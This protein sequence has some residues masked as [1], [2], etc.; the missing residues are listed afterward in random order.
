MLCCC[1]Q[2]CVCVCVYVLQ[3]TGSVA[4]GWYLWIY[5]AAALIMRNC[6]RLKMEARWGRGCFST[7]GEDEYETLACVIY[8]HTHTHTHTFC[9]HPPSLLLLFLVVEIHRS[10]LTNIKGTKES[11]NKA[12]VPDPFYKMKKRKSKAAEEISIPTLIPA[13]VNFQCRQPLRPVKSNV[14]PGEG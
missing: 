12:K 10:G 3:K 11:I 4:P 14:T 2:H 8:W 7:G 5:K 6:T 1:G 9:I 13:L